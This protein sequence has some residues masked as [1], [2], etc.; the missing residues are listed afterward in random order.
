M[1]ITFVNHASFLL[2]T[3]GVTIWSDPWTKGKVVDDCC[4]LFS[5][6]PDVPY[7]KVD[8]IWIS[9][10]H[11]DHFHF[12]TLKAIPAEERKRITILHQKH[13]SPRV[14]DALRKLGF[15]HIKEL[16]LY[17]WFTLKPGIEMLCGSVGTM[18]SFLAVRAEGECVLNL[19]DCICKDATLR[20]IQRLVGKVSVLLT[21]FSIAQWIGNKKDETDAV[22]QKLREVKYRIWTFKP[23]FT[24][25]F[26]SFGYFCNEDN[27]WMNEFMV[28]PAFLA[29]L[30]LPGVNF[31]YPGDEWNSEERTFRSSEAVAKYLKDLEHLRIDPLPPS[32]EA[33]PIRLAVEKLLAGLRKRFGQRILRR[34]QPFGVHTHDTN[35]IFRIYPAEGRCE[36][37]EATPQEAESARYVMCSQVAWYTFAHSWGWN[38]VEGGAMYIDRDFNQKGEAE[39]WRRCVTEYST[40]ILRFNTPDRIRRTLS[41]VWGKKF[42]I[43]YHLT[44]KAISDEA[45][46]EITPKSPLGTATAQAAS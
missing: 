39:L 45:V 21:Q 36:V 11:S 6:S 26:A 10:E 8:Y 24:I 13:S 38:V 22:A 41:F 23:E 44:G 29:S 20:Y 40:D 1:K 7:K 14:V 9:H 25:P 37:R 35:K 31:M 19:N 28:T 18:D 17:R 43:F 42:E 16:P 34:L 33:E 30:N 12:P 27:C 5:P 4:A 2:E 15:E 32:V 46:A 3:C